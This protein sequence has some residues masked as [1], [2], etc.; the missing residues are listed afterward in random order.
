MRPPS[1]ARSDGSERRV[2]AFEDR[3]GGEPEMVADRCICVPSK[4]TPGIRSAT[5]S[6]ATSYENGGTDNFQ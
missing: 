5:S 6:P 3:R 2:T 1:G 4:E